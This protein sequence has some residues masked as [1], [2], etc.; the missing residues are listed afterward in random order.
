[1]RVRV[2]EKNQMIRR[3]RYTENMSMS[4]KELVCD[5]QIKVPGIRLNA[6]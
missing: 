4:R 2:T 6:Y 3:K 1:M 5:R